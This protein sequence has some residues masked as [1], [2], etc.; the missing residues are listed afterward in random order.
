MAEPEA[1]KRPPLIDL[2]GFIVLLGFILFAA[3]FTLG[4]TWEALA[5]MVVG[6]ACAV[7]GR[8]LAH[9]RRGTSYFSA[10]STDANSQAP[11]VDQLGNPP[12]H[13]HSVHSDRS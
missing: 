7:A 4:F 8:E 6:L 10:F 5:L 2:G 12:S 13:T 1:G 11:R 3:S 9:K